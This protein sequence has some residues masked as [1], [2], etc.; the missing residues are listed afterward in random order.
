ML[1]DIIF[2]NLD[3]FDDIDTSDVEIEDDYSDSPDFYDSFFENL[4]NSDDDKNE[5]GSFTDLSNL[6][7]TEN[8]EIES[9]QHIDN[10]ASTISFTGLGRCR[11]CNCGRW[12]GFGDTCENCG[13]LFNK[14]I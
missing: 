14:H 1:D 6:S 10:K 2:D 12:A 13:H 3:S 8:I 7:S 9:H 5:D 11:V 4:D